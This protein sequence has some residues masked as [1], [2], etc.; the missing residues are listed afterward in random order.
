LDDSRVTGNRSIF[1][2]TLRPRWILQLKSNIHLAT[3]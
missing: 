3:Q 1:G 2:Y